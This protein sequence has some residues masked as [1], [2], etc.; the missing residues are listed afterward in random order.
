MQTT[1]LSEEK[2]NTQEFIDLE[3]LYNA[4][5]YRPLDVVVERGEGM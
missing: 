3:N 2:M 1:M 4:H 5:N